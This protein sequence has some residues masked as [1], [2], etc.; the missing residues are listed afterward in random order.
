M[1]TPGCSKSG[2]ICGCLTSRRTAESRTLRRCYAAMPL[3]GGARG[4]NQGNA[5]RIGRRFTAMLR[6]QFRVENLARRGRDELAS[7][8][9]YARE[10]VA[11]FLFRFRGI[12]LKIADLGEAEKMD[13]FCR[14]L[15][16]SVR[17][18]VE[19]RGPA[20]FQEAAT[21]AE[22][23]DAVLSRVPGQDFG[24]GWQK[25]KPQHRGTFVSPP[26]YKTPPSGSGSGAGAGTGAGS[27]PEPME[28]G[29]IQR[30]PLTQKE[31]ARLRMN[32]GC[33]YCRQENAGHIARNCPMKAK[34]QG[35]PSGR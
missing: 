12:C 31:M 16:P 2:N 18:Q 11:D 3:C 6:A 9:Q 13:R 5:L 32:K 15:L 7:V 19:L 21:Y 34:R 23:A 27:G 25:K 4:A 14:A 29:S 8:Q 10:S 24:G 22:R 28:I 35:N 17:L 26:S 33:F 30:K 20:T 1:L